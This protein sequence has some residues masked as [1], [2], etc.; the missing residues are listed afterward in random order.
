M[1]KALGRAASGFA[2]G[3]L[4]GQL[5]AILISLGM[6]DGRFHQ[7][8]PAFRLMFDT[9]LG[10]VIAQ[11][12]LPGLIGATFAASSVIF[13]VEKWGITTQYVTHFA[14]TTSVW[15]PLVYLMWRP[16]STVGYIIC[17]A[18]FA[19]TYAVIWLVQFL[20]ARRDVG[21]INQHL[22]SMDAERQ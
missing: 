2:F 10:A 15:V 17:A 3:V 12:I 18:S 11:T 14:I 21:R 19:A 1:G 16:Q 22:R 6:G 5:V 9:E 20:L 4:N 13:E 7:V 8:V